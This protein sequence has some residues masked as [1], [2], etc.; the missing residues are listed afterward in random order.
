[1]L[2]GLAVNWKRGTPVAAAVD[3]VSVFF[4]SAGWPNVKPLGIDA[5]S[6]LDVERATAET[7]NMT[8]MVNLI[9]ILKYNVVK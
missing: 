1:M 4:F 6:E 8:N 9:D 7:R 2:A 5:F 3:P